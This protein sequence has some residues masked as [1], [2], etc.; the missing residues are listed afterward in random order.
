M[1][2]RSGL[3]KLSVISQVSA[4]EGVSVKQGSTVLCTVF[5]AVIQTIIT[6]IHVTNNLVN[7]KNFVTSSALWLVHMLVS[8]G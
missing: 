8:K 1:K 3:S 7:F 2:I 4:V 6:H 5:D